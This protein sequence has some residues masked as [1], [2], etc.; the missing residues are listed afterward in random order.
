MLDKQKLIIRLKWYLGFFF[1]K[2]TV[3]IK[4]FSMYAP[5]KQ[6]KTDRNLTFSELKVDEIDDLIRFHDDECTKWNFLFSKE[7]VEQRF[8]IGHKC[9]VAKYEGMI[10][11]MYWTGIREVYSPDLES[12]FLVPSDSTIS[13]NAYVINKHRGKNIL[14]IL[15]QMAFQSFCEN[16]YSWSYGYSLTTNTSVNRSNLKY[17]PDIEGKIDYG[18]AMGYRYL[19]PKL[20]K[21]CRLR[22]RKEYNPWHRWKILH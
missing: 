4:K 10:V 12:T 6:F 7:D 15:R 20:S 22:T 9:Y 8:L 18:Y 1:S 16:G 2:Q 5:H 21:N 14:P 3:L 11:G 19:S 17:K 13:Y